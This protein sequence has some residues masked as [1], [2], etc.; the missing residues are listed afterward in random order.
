[1]PTAVPITGKAQH[2]PQSAIPVKPKLLHQ[3]LFV[4]AIVEIF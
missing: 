1:M 2:K 3:L 4:V